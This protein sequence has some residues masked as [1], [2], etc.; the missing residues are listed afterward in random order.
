MTAMSTLGIGPAAIDLRVRA[1]DG[2]LSLADMLCLVWGWEWVFALGAAGEFSSLRHLIVSVPS[3]TYAR[4]AI[5]Y[6]AGGAQWCNL[7]ITGYAWGGAYP[8]RHFWVTDQTAFDAWILE[9]RRR[10]T[11]GTL[12]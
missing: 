11:A 12:L 4:V 2:T 7:G 8:Y 6:L 1:D 3:D 5:V 10:F 9:V